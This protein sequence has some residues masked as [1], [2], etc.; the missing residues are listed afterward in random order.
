MVVRAYYETFGLPITISICSNNYGVYQFPEKLIPYFTIRLIND[1]KMPLYRSSL[2]RRE[3]LQVN[4][5][6]RAID[7]I[8]KKGQVGETYN[9]GSGYEVD[10]ETIADMLLDEFGMNSAYKE[11]VADRPGHDRRYLLDST[12]IQRELGWEPRIPFKQGF[13][14]TVRWY[15]QNE[16]WWRPLLQKLRV[17]EGAWSSG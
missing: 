13:S 5:H 16:A 2:N 17:D 4:D 11:Y 12:K 8:L 3:W 1:Q 14:D 15:K 7:T 10:V 6:C 9:V